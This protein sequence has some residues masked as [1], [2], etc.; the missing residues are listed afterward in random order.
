MRIK[1]SDPTRLDE[2]R[3]FFESV[4]AL[5]T[6]DDETVTVELAGPRGQA[7]TRQLRA[8][9]QTWLSL[10]AATGQRVEADVDDA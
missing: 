3:D 10:R 2:L 1:L 6:H 7:D 9:L 8:Y 5:A 4:H